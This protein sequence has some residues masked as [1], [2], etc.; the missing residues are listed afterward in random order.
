MKSPKCLTLVLCTLFVV[1]YLHVSVSAQSAEDRNKLTSMSSMGSSV[2]W[3]VAAPNSGMTMIVSAPDGRVF[4]KE[5]KAGSSPEF[6]ITD[7]Q[8]DRL[9][10]GAYT[11]ELRL[12]PVLSPA[13]KQE[14]AAA[15]GKDDDPEDVRATRKRVMLPAMVQ[16]GTFSI[17][18]GAIVVAGATEETGRRPTSKST[19]QSPAISSGALTKSLQHH[20]L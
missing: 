20:P 17:L 19:E 15:R 2:R 16:S 6:M 3:D 5:F 4:R 14:L 10:D 18:N 8:G 7:K 13:V 9:P 11:Y 12:S 1:A